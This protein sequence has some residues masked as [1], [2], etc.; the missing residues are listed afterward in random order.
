MTNIQLI[1]ELLKQNSGWSEHTDKWSEIMNLFFAVASHCYEKGDCNP[2]WKFSVGWSGNMIEEDSINY[3]T[4]LN[5]EYE[6]LFECGDYL[7]RLSIT[8][9]KAGLSY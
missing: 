2:I 1:K 6:D 5:M 9:D 3:E 7:H 4:F 8:F